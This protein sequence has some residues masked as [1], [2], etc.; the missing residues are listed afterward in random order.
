MFGADEQ[1]SIRDAA[2]LPRETVAPDYRTAAA[3][4]SRL[5]RDRV[6]FRDDGG[7]S[8]SVYLRESFSRLILEQRIGGGREGKDEFNLFR[9]VRDDEG[10]FQFWLFIPE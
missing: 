10:R 5:L 6:E 3:R 2:F 9:S 8:F 7:G 1:I 4:A